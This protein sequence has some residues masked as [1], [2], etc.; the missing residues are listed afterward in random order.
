MNRTERSE[1]RRLPERGSHDPKVIHEV[2]DAAFL[3][4]VGFSASAQPFVI[5]M[6]YGRDGDTLYLHG[7]TASRALLVLT[8]GAPACVSVTLIDGLVLARSA[9]HHSLNYRSVVAFG[10]ACAIAEAAR[11]TRAM[12]VISEHCIAGRWRDVRGPSRAELAAT[13]VL[14]FTI[15]EVSA[16]IRRGP[17]IEDDA[18]YASTAWAGVVPLVLQPQTPVSDPRLAAGIEV[19]TYLTSGLWSK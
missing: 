19:P 4:H 2:L 14:E 17:P 18:D 10:T 16:K 15:E 8:G 1:L 6:I 9:F 13:T 12:R 5:P 11:K 7:S 3:A